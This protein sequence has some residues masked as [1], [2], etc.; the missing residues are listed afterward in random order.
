RD[1][2]ADEVS[3]PQA[4]PLPRR[5]HRLDVDSPADDER[6]VQRPETHVLPHRG[7]VAV[8]A[9]DDGIGGVLGTAGAGR[10]EVDPPIQQHLALH[11]GWGKSA[12]VLDGWRCR[13]VAHV[14]ARAGA[15]NRVRPASRAKATAMSSA[16]PLNTWLTHEGVPTSV[17]PLTVTAMKRIATTTPGTDGR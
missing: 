2:A 11:R 4:P 10:F 8:R 9:D 17:R 15:V 1:R 7:C 14:A 5:G 16:A 13:R 3:R 12:W 6:G